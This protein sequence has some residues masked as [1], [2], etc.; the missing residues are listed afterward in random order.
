MALAAQVLILVCGTGSL[1]RAAGLFDLGGR[2]RP[3][4]HPPRD[5]TSRDRVME[6]VPHAGCSNLQKPPFLLISWEAVLA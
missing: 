6:M 3:P 2:H 1:V 4:G 5:L